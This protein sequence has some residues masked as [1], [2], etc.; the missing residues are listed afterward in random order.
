MVAG[1]IAGGIASAVFYTVAAGVYSVAIRLTSYFLESIPG[2]VLHLILI[3]VLYS[4]PERSH[5]IDLR[6][7]ET[8][9]N[10]PS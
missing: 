1:R 6:Y 7:H 8:T 3:P 2:I 10:Q 5:I 9:I 4:A